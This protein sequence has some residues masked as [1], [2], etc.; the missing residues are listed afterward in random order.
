M[1]IVSL[2]YSTYSRFVKCVVDKVGWVIRNLLNHV[3]TDGSNDRE[4]EKKNTREGSKTAHLNGQSLFPNKPNV[5]RSLEHGSGAVPCSLDFSTLKSTSMM[6]MVKSPD[7]KFECRLD[8]R[9]MG[10]IGSPSVGSVTGGLSS[11]VSPLSAI[12]EKTD[13]ER[14]AVLSD[15]SETKKFICHYCN[16]EFSIRGYLTRHIKKHA[17]EKAYQ[18]PFYNGD[19]PKEEQCH[20]NGGFSRRD[21]FKTHLISRHF[22]CPK[23]VKCQDKAK[24]S[25]HCMHCK[26]FHENTDGWIKSHVETGECKGLPEGFKVAAAKKGRRGGKL[27]KIVTS[28]GHSRFISTDKSNVDKG[29]GDSISNLVEDYKNTCLKLPTPALPRA[30]NGE[31]SMFVSDRGLG[32]AFLH[33]RNLNSTHRSS[34]LSE[35]ISPIGGGEQNLHHQALDSHYAFDYITPSKTTALDEG[36]FSVDPSPTEDA[37]LDTVKSTSSASSRTSSHENQEKPSMNSALYSAPQGPAEDVQFHFPL[38]LDQCPLSMQFPGIFD[39]AHTGARNSANFDCPNRV[40]SQLSDILQRQMDAATLGEKNLR[41][42]QQYLNFYNNTFKS[43]L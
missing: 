42:N 29:S 23:G 5:D 30:S 39:G 16:A 35:D 20:R 10:S 26:T 13:D 18:C 34:P 11:V 14:K 43:H 38:D 27:K 7:G 17:V 2:L 25:G 41:E 33:R 9:L 15:S 37:V 24:S 31:P 3:V 28:D 36:S 19:L 8:D 6:S 21:T 1:P 12:H 22:L 32:G 40:T 4:T